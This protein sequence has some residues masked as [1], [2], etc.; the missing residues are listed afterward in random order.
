M[1]D[2]VHPRPLLPL[3][4]ALTLGLFLGDRFSGF[5]VS[6]IGAAGWLAAFVWIQRRPHRPVPVLLALF[7]VLGH[8]LIQPWTAPRFPPHHIVHRIGAGSVEVSGRVAA[9]LPP[10]R[11]GARFLVDCRQLVRGPDT[12]PAAGR[13]RVFSRGGAP[14]MVPGD[15]VVFRTTV[16]EPSAYGNPGGFDYRRYL[17]RRGIWAVGRTDRRRIRVLPQTVFWGWRPRLERLRQ[18]IAGQI[19]QAAGESPAAA[20]LLALVIGQRGGIDS[21][22]RDAFNRAGVGHLLAISGLHLGMVATVGFFC[23]RWLLAWVPFFLWR[24]WVVRGAAVLAMAPMLGYGALA[25]PAPSTQRAMIMVATALVA[26]LIQ[27][28]QDLLNT[29]AAAA[30]VILMASPPAL[31]SLSFQL[32]F[33]AVFA[34]VYGLPRVPE[35]WRKPAGGLAALGVNYFWVSLLALLGTLPIAMAA[36]HQVSLVGLAANLFLVPLVGFAIV[37]LGLTAALAGAVFPSL[38]VA[39]FQ[40]GAALTDAALGL[41][42][43]FAGLP[44]AALKTFPP[45]V[46]ET[47]GFYALGW[48][49]LARLDGASASTVDGRRRV[50]TMVMAGLAVAACVDAGYWLQHRFWHR[51]LRVTVLDVGQGSAALVEFPGGD[52]MLI[53][54]G[55]FSDN[56]V[57]DVGRRL[58]A[59]V[60]LRKRIFTVDTVVL[61]HPNADHLNG[62]IHIA[63]HFNVGQVWTNGEAANSAGYRRFKAVLGSR[64]VKAPDY[65]TLSRRRE[66][67]GVDLEILYPPP[68]FMDLKKIHPW[69]DANNNSMVLRLAAFGKSFL[70]TGDISREAEAELIRRAGGRIQSTVL[71]VPHHGSRH[72]STPAF[73][74]TVRPKVA[75]AS[76]GRRNRFGFPHPRTLS[77]YERLSCRL[78]RTDRDGAVAFRAK[79][80]TLEIETAAE[81]E[82]PVSGGR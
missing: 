44:F 1:A 71:M 14:P 46:P 37:P 34:I 30:L 59:P 39:G 52:T 8:Q 5:A 28:E 82:P 51:D 74:A 80:N 75:V 60:L 47:L 57:F 20:V 25:G 56:S 67:G 16:Q 49:L 70:F 11:F 35:S 7:L 27:R 69:R 72:S 45:S 22:L 63:E 6:W 42:H 38:G 29:L 65:R 4:A 79:D 62:L 10:T 78:L 18:S 66:I 58:V 40:V 26:L 17:A 19:G 24:G 55:G 68:N 43:G 13:L 36:F 41:I 73:L 76:A 81:Y 53:D 12:K 31:F 9:V 2:T 61:S 33:A 23:F 48:A 15:R 54:G 77:R 50:A 3:A 21:V 64:S 32:S